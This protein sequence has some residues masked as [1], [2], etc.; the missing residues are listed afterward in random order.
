MESSF[1]E[2]EHTSW[3]DINQGDDMNDDP[4]EDPQLVLKE[5]LDK[6]KTPDYI[7]EP[8]ICTQLKKYFQAGGNPE[9]VI[10]LLSRNYTACAQMANLLAEWLIL[11][12]V[13]LPDVQ[14]MVE[15]SMKEMILKN[16]DPKKADKIFLSSDE[17]ETPG[18]MTDMIQHPTWR[19]LIYKLAEEYPDCL[20]LNFTIKLISDA[21]YQGEITSIS[22]AAQQI[23][24]FSRVLKTTIA[25]FLQNIGQWQTSIQECAR[26][27]CHGQHT[28]VYSQLLLH[29]LSHENK[30]GF[31][32]KRLS[33]EITKCAQVN[34]HDVTPITLALNGAAS[35]PGAC[36][37]L[38][39][40]LSRNSLNPADITVLYRNYNL[41]D[42]PPIELI[43]NP[44]FLELL[45]DALFKPGVKI[46][47]EHKSKY[48]YLLAYA[49]SV[50]E[51]STKK[52]TQRKINK[53]D[54]KNT[55][56]SIEK[57]H[58]ICN[59]NKGSTELIAEINTLFEC[60]KS[61]VVSAGVIRWVES[62]V[63]EPSY[64]KLC[65]EHCPIHLALLDEVVGL[66][67]LLHPKVLR[68]LIQLFES[69][70]DELEILV[71]LEL[72]K[73][74]ID[75]MV[76]ILCKG[77]VVPTVT[78]IKQCWQKGDTDISLIRY[79]VTEVLEAI[80]PPYSKD[81]V[82]LFLPLVEHEEIT[83]SMR[84]DNDN[85]LVSEFIVYCKA[86]N[87]NAK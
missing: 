44:Q 70:Q 11:A 20:M 79:F 32:M 35:S 10:D 33:Q 15:N 68:L 1:N 18:W 82:Q 39:S 53:D 66:H 75:R 31:M 19:S 65:T 29:I 59:T 85:D 41:P 42:P 17:I 63:T 78:Y 52:G 7:M 69:K 73:M 28:Y 57:V 36:L 80:V 51:T 26:M 5:C 40:M 87:H 81:F 45:V 3:E 8:G 43:R 64:F 12:G 50:V 13:K 74:L 48:M 22:T 77:C 14:A 56:Q 60:I 4:S 27:V 30:G 25:N 55:I 58:N 9:T 76:H 71:Q 49:A 34:G 61:P 84:G 24:V 67:N 21:G 37:A 6:F 38:S 86:Q 72:K 2:E 83:G 23:E 54:L 16:F 46:N 47:S 62:T